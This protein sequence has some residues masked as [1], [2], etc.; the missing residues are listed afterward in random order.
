MSLLRLAL[1]LIRDV[2]TTEQG[3]EFIKDLRGGPGKKTRTAPA[4]EAEVGPWRQSVE[5]RLTV[6]DRNATMLAGM[7]NAQHEAMIRIQKRQRIWNVA[8]AAGVLLA[9]AVPLAWWLLAGA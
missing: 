1:G 4:G 6:A 7:L 3:Q 9:L 2:A 8:L 5:E